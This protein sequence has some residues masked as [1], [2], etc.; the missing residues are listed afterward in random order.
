MNRMI[1]EHFVRVGVV[2]HTHGDTMDKH[3]AQ[4]QIRPSFHTK[5][6][7]SSIECHDRRSGRDGE[8]HGGRNGSKQGNHAFSDLCYPLLYPLNKFPNPN[9]LYN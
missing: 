1:W 4:L 2:V 8:V 7:T 6:G 5:A 9:P 3:R